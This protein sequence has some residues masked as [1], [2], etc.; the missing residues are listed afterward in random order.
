LGDFIA[1]V[2]NPRENFDYVAPKNSEKGRKTRKTIRD[3]IIKIYRFFC[4]KE[5]GFLAI[6]TI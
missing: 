2:I 4:Q 3:R 5:L 6:K 1:F